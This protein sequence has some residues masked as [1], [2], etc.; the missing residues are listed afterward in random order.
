MLE[1]GMPLPRI[2]GFDRSGE[3]EIKVLNDGSL[4]VVFSMLPPET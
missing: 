3:P 2:K 1:A 4:A